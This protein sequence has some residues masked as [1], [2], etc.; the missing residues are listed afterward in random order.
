LIKY[1]TKALR[2]SFFGLTC[3]LAMPGCF[4]EGYYRIKVTNVPCVSNCDT[5]NLVQ[6]LEDDYTLGFVELDDQGQFYDRGQVE[7][8]IKWLKNEKQPQYVT[9]FVQCQGK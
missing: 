5:A 7:A 1:F 9:I 6:H 3:L 4:Q 2:V 8:L